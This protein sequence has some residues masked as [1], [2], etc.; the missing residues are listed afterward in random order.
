MAAS[1]EACYCHGLEHRYQQKLSVD[2]GAEEQKECLSLS[3]Y[4]NLYLNIYRNQET[5]NNY[6]GFFFVCFV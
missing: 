3:R 5:F 1:S 4:V 6:C 2:S